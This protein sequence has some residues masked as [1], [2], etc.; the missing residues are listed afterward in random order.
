MDELATLNNIS[1]SDPFD[2]LSKAV[3]I[4]LHTAW[5]PSYTLKPNKIELFLELDKK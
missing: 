5:H 3:T 4:V 1:K 2:I